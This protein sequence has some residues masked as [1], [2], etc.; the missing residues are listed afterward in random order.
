MAGTKEPNSF[1]VEAEFDR[2][3]KN[4]TLLSKP[5]AK[6]DSDVGNLLLPV[7]QGIQQTLVMLRDLSLVLLDIE[8]LV[9]K[10]YAVCRALDKRQHN[11]RVIV[12]RKK[13][14]D[15]DSLV[16]HFRRKWLVVSHRSRCF[17]KIILGDNQ[18]GKYRCR[19]F[20]SCLRFA[21]CKILFEMI[22]ENPCQLFVCDDRMPVAVVVSNIGPSQP[23]QR[24]VLVIKRRLVRRRPVATRE[25][26]PF[27]AQAARSRALAAAAEDRNFDM[28]GGRKQP[29]WPGNRCWRPSES[30]TSIL[31]ERLHHLFFRPIILFGSPANIVAFAV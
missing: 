23:F 13:R 3:A 4:V 14:L 28:I 15:L 1:L 17:Q 18:V 26:E 29:A 30:L 12:G 11:V 22:A 5:A 21:I 20:L 8:R 27:A 24:V 19:S 31:L 6:D 2:V 25:P 7:Q 16:N 9:D 10:E